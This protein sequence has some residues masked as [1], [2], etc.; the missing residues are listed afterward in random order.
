MFNDAVRARQDA[1]AANLPYPKA[2]ELSQALIT[3]AKR[4]VERSWLGEVS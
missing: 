1:H 3:Q 2:A 4:T